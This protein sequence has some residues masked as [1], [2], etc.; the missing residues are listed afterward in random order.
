MSSSGFHRLARGNSH[1]SVT[2]VTRTPPPSPSFLHLTFRT[3]FLIL[4]ENERG[5]EVPP[6]GRRLEEEEEEAEVLV[7][8]VGAAFS[9]RGRL[10]V[11][12]DGQVG[13]LGRPQGGAAQ[14]QQH[15]GGH[16]SVPAGGTV[17]GAVSPLGS[18]GGVKGSGGLPSGVEVPQRVGDVAGHPQHQ[19]P[20]TAQVFDHDG[21][22]EHGGD[23]HG[24]VD[25]AQRGYAHPLLRIQAALRG[26]R[27]DT[28]RG[29]TAGCERWPELLSCSQT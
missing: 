18:A 16:Q 4:S 20:L 11:P 22:D 24:G 15:R 7:D 25:D 10:G 19:A 23:D 9:L 14:P 13:G 29:D 2:T 27:R 6:H 8:D 12:G 21:G 17:P 3:Y 5:H 26:R 28:V 1:S